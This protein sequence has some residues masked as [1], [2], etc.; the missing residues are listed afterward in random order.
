MQIVLEF[1][2]LGV[3]PG[4]EAAGPQ[5]RPRLLDQSIRDAVLG[6]G[7]G[8]SAGLQL[9]TFEVL[10]RLSRKERRK[11]QTLEEYLWGGSSKHWCTGHSHSA[12][13][14]SCLLS[15]HRQKGQALHLL[16]SI[17]SFHMSC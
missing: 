3:M 16:A 6:G 11:E 17:G 14:R 15:G 4:E 2:M 7:Q 1:R 13:L 8:A 10:E 12:S 9:A 5:C